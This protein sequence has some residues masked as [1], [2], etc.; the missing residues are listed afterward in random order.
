MSSSIRIKVQLGE[1]VEN[2]YSRNT[3]PVIKFIY[4]ID[5]PS[6]KTIDVL[7]RNLQQYI[8]EQFLNNNTQIVQLTTYDGFIL[9]KTDLCSVVLKDND[10]ILCIDMK[11]FVE[12][13]TST[14]DFDNLWLEFKQH[15]ASDDREKSIQIGLNTYSKLFIRMYG[16]LNLYGLYIFSIFEL[17][18][19]A[20]AKRQSMKRNF[21]Y[22]KS[23]IIF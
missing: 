3:I 5:S 7:I 6:N 22:M 19:I 18:K 11:K 1:D 16:N 20:S 17:I 4:I 21:V 14:I 10:H 12:E 13:N 15:D 2:N 9:P 8:N 23:S